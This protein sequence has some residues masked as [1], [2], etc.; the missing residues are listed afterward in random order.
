MKTTANDCAPGHHTEGEKNSQMVTTTEAIITR[1]ADRLADLETTVDEAKL[2]MARAF[3]TIGAALAMI[4]QDQLVPNFDTYVEERFGI[5]RRHAN[6]CIAALEIIEALGP[7]GPAITT[8]SQARVLSGLSPDDAREV[9]EGAL[10]LTDGTLTASALR[11]VRSE[12]LPVPADTR[13][14]EPTARQR[15]A[16]L[17]RSIEAA[18][19]NVTYLWM[20]DVCIHDHER[21]LFQSF[22]DDLAGWLTEVEVSY[23]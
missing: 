2:D 11:S 13:P 17:V 14:A 4:R 7:D 12:L 22:A 8:E 10:A 18:Q 23:E 19:D 9:V 5:S 15:V 1:K 21:E 20:D 16:R 3:V 6:R